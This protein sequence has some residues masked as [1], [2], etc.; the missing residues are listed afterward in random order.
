L[1]G[2]LAFIVNV[3]ILIWVAR[4]LSAIHRSR[5]IAILGTFFVGVVLSVVADFTVAFSVDGYDRSIQAIIER[6]IM[7]GLLA[8]IVGYL[9]V[10]RAAKNS[11]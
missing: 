1:T 11:N 3:A 8:M 9:V 6:G 4:W 2:A 7:S 5:L 10:R